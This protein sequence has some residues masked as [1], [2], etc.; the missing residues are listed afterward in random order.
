MVTMVAQTN[1]LMMEYDD[2][3]MIMLL[4]CNSEDGERMRIWSFVRNKWIRCSC[5]EKCCIMLMVENYLEGILNF[6]PDFIFD[7]PKFWFK[8]TIGTGDA[9]HC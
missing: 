1:N 2:D 9:G 8:T 7:L 5:S 4:G 3:G 6:V